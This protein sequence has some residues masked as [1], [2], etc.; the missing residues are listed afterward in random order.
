MTLIFRV[1]VGDNVIV[2]SSLSPFFLL[3]NLLCGCRTTRSG[4]SPS[5]WRCRIRARTCWL[6]TARWRWRIG[7]THS[8][9]SCTVA[10]RS[11]CRR[12]GTETCTMVCVYKAPVGRQMLE[13]SSITNILSDSNSIL[14]TDNIDIIM[15]L[16]LQT[17]YFKQNVR[18]YWERWRKNRLC[19]WWCSFRLSYVQNSQFIFSLVCSVV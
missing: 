3:S 14:K 7:S 1:D 16:S 17:E 2:F 6:Q 10:L 8:T 4:G 15:K 13:F 11:P 5:S 12:R 19:F 9:K 18:Y